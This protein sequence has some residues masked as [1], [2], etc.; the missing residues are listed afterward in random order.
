M[1]EW[2]LRKDVIGVV[3][4]EGLEWVEFFETNSPYSAFDLVVFPEGVELGVTPARYIVSP[5]EVKSEDPAKSYKGRHGSGRLIYVKPDPDGLVDVSS[6][7]DA[8]LVLVGGMHLG[9][10]R[11]FTLGDLFPE[12]GGM[13][14]V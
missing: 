2:K 13:S 7:G 4:E 12:L 14:R 10:K 9:R 3:M 6:A 8:E 11:G 1:G 5:F